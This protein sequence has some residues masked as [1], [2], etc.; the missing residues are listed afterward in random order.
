MR[1][2]L[3]LWVQG[4]KFAAVPHRGC[5]MPCATLICADPHDR[6]SSAYEQA[7]SGHAGEHAVLVW[8]LQ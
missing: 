1:V 8:A 3:K 5:V 4:Q 6:V 7:A 2:S